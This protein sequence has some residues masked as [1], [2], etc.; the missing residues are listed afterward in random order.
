MTQPWPVQITARTPAACGAVLWRTAGT[1][2]VTVVLKATFALIH[3]QL[4]TVTTPREIIH[5]DR[6]REGSGCLEEASET[7][8]YL[9]TAGVLLAGHAYAPGGSAAPTAAARLAVARERPL[10]DKTVHV[11]GDRAPGASPPRPFQK[12]PLAYERAYGGPGVLEN[13]A[14]V[15]AGRTTAQPNLLD[16]TNPQRPAGFG[17]ISRYWPARRRLLGNGDDQGLQASDPVI[18]Q[19]FDWCYFH[20]A[21]P[22]QQIEL[23]RGDEW[24]VLDGLHPSL[25][26]VQTKLPSAVGRA[27][28]HLATSTSLGPA[29]DIPL[30][31]DMLVIDADEQL[32]SVVWRGRF[33]L[34]RPDLAPWVRVFVGVELGGQSVVWSPSQD[35]STVQLGLANTIDAPVRLGPNGPLPLQRPSP[36]PLAG[37]I[38]TDLRGM[39][40]SILPFEALEVGRIPSL[41]VSREVLQP[42]IRRAPES[43]A[44]TSELDLRAV[45][46]AIVPFTSTRAAPSPLASTGGMG[47]GPLKPALPFEQ[48]D[49]LKPVFTAQPQSAVHRAPSLLGGTADADM[50]QAMRAS[51]P[52]VGTPQ[53]GPHSM[54]PATAPVSSIERPALLPEPPPIHPPPMMHLPLM[55]APQA[56]PVYSMPPMMQLP[57]T[58]APQTQPVYATPTMQASPPFFGSQNEQASSLTPPTPVLTDRTSVFQSSTTDIAKATSA[59]A[60][61]PAVDAR[62]LPSIASPVFAEAPTKIKGV[63]ESA[64]LRAQI[65]ARL[66]AGEPLQGLSLVDAD[67][68]EIDF[69]GASLSRL[70]L[71]RSNLVRANLSGVQAAETQFEG[72]NFSEANLANADLT[73]AN[74]SRTTVTKACFDS[75]TLTGANLQRLSGDE[76]SFRAAKLHGADLRHTRLPGAIFED[77]ILRNA[78]VSQ[79]DL[80]SACFVRADLTGANLR[81][82]KLRDANFSL[83]NLEGADLRDAVLTRANVHGASRKGAKINPAQVKDLVEIDP[84]Q[85][86]TS[87]K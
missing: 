46:A 59:L 11:F 26:R 58:S 42:V 50:Q 3:G 62:P 83:A 19:G 35:V 31:A 76:T 39:L 69:K 72:A 48:A 29:Q 1:S 77:A 67:L 61:A 34:Q 2:W 28:W 79:A 65:V 85:D 74:L 7:P 73:R 80:A 81:E 6:Y 52:F 32:C 82:S 37:T 38:D 87:R 63:D 56:P 30:V 8:P 14:G 84:E 25:P 47:D 33:P 21:P 70:D 41:A 43:V 44:E 45:L 20:A 86:S 64:S 78:S 18:P 12:M 40:A 23:L 22:D 66:K 27:R 36:S 17:P 57:S 9:P 16:P 75:A 24:L 49:P 5:R 10:L 4:A 55:S 60:P 53:S 54:D 68:H 13:P 71:R 15:G 51:L